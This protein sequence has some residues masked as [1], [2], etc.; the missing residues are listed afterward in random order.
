M[1]P[2][3]WQTGK[4]DQSATEWAVKHTG[5]KAWQQRL[6]PVHT[7]PRQGIRKQATRKYRM[8]EGKTEKSGRIP[9]GAGKKAVGKLKMN[10]FLIT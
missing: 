8:E 5:E 9:Q 6:K 2:T 3:G 10:Y 7:A 4:R 1:Q